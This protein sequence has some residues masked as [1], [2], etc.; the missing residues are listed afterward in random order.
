MIYCQSFLYRFVSLGQMATI[1][2]QQDDDFFFFL[3]SRFQFETILLQG[4]GQVELG[5][6]VTAK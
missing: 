3:I 2:S 5:H 6:N 1:S 4:Y